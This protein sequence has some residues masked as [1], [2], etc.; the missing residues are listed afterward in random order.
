MPA[1]VIPRINAR[2]ESLIIFSSYDSRYLDLAAPLEIF[3][4]APRHRTRDCVQNRRKYPALSTLKYT[5]INDASN[6][7][8][9]SIFKRKRKKTPEGSS[10]VAGPAD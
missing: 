2:D 1:M 8:Y 6:W 10:C 4:Q 5:R 9:F 7:G 3:Y